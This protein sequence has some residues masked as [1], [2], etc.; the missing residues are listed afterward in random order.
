M[1]KLFLEEFI[2]NQD[3]NVI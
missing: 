1:Q 2:M 3:S